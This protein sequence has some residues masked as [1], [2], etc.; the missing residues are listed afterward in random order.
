MN[1]RGGFDTEINYVSDLSSWTDMNGFVNFRLFWNHQ[2]VAA[3]HQRGGRARRAVSN[4]VNTFNTPRDR[5]NIS[6]GY[7]YEGFSA[8]ITE[9]YIAPAELVR[10]HQSRRRPGLSKIR[11]FRPIT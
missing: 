11:R 1:S 3:V 2:E 5:A 4:N 9:Q 10:H 6:L 7:S 8:T